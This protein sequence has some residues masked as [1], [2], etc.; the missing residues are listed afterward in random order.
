MD[1]PFKE[2][3]IVDDEPDGDGPLP[4]RDNL[5]ANAKG[6]AKSPQDRRHGRGRRWSLLEPIS[7]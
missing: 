1:G 5:K 6:K 2:G 7:N 4:R 3:P